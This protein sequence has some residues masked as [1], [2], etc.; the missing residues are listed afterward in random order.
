MKRDSNPPPSGERPTPPPSPPSKAKPSERFGESLQQLTAV[1]I[2]LAPILH[3]Y[4]SDEED[5]RSVADIVRDV[6]HDLQADRA[7]ALKLPRLERER[8]AAQAQVAALQDRLVRL[9]D[10]AGRH[11]EAAN[12]VSRQ[13]DNGSVSEAAHMILAEAGNELV[14]ARVHA[15]H[16]L[17]DTAQA[18]AD[19]ERRVLERAADIAIQRYNADMSTAYDKRQAGLADHYW[20]G[21]ASA[22][23]A[24]ATAI[25]A[26]ADKE[27]EG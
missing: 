6:V 15:C 23:E 9:N 7:D 21:G 25:R 20:T 13:L 8:D 10:W 2:E 4:Q 26:L 12:Q 22:A 19:H 5:A 27:G 24:I 3:W 18:A 11:L 1:R 17:S 16:A 14:K